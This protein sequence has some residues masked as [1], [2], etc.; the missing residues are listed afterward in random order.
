MQEPD[1]AAPVN[2]P[3][4]WHTAGIGWTAGL[5]NGLIALGG[6]V[7]VTPWLVGQRRVD[8]QIAVGTSLALVTVLSTIGFAAHYALGGLVLGPA[9][10]GV[11]VLGGM[12]GAI[13]GTRLLAHLTPRW[14]LVAFA[15]FVLAV[16]AR[17]ILQG[18]GFFVT[19]SDGAQSVP[20]LAFFA[21][22]GVSGVLSG[23]F[24]V[25]GGALVLL[26]LAGF[27]G[28]PVQEG[29]PIALALNVSNALF[30]V[31][32][33]MRAGRVMWMEVKVLVAAAV[34]GIALGAWLAL[35]LPPDT[36]R[37][38][39]GGFFLFMGARIARQGWRLA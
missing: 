24:G 7:I 5:L 36:M 20:L 11:S 35:Q 33:H 15:V 39:F 1:V 17:L 12:S 29:L 21:F 37:V 18:I 23:V 27:Y 28:L 6:G 31:I 25:G 10:I 16:A 22:G 9:A 19:Q 34:S 26:G 2:Q 13:I 38:I 30:G 3:R 8:P 14:M 32:H 4:W